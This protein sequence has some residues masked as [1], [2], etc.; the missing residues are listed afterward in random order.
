MFTSCHLG[1]N[2]PSNALREEALSGNKAKFLITLLVSI[3]TC[4]LFFRFGLGLS[5]LSVLC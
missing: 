5:I 4:L 1:M 3:L 2:N